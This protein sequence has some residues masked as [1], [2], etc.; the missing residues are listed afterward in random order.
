VGI[1]SDQAHN[2][3]LL[4]EDEARMLGRLRVEP[5]HLL[6]ALARSG[7]VHR[8]LGELGVSP[9]HIHAAIVAGGGLGDDLVLGRVPWSPA[10]VAVLERAVDAAAARGVH[11]PSSEHVMLGLRDDPGATAVLDRVGISD[12]EAFIDDKYPATRAPLSPDRLRGQIVRASFENSAPRPGPGP[13]VFERFTDEAERSVRAAV[14]CA[15]LLEHGTVQPLH[16]LL[17]CIHVADSVAGTALS[18]VFGESEM[19]AIGE[20]MER[21]RMYG[22]SPARQATGIFTDQ[23]RQILAEDALKLAY[24]Q[25]HPQITTGHLLLAT[26][27]VRDQA[28]ARLIGDGVMRGGPLTDRLGREVARAEPGREERRRA[29]DHD[30]IQMDSAIKTLAAEFSKIVPA[31]WTLR[32]SGRS[33]GIRLWAPDSTSERDFRIDLD[34]V[35]AVDGLAADRLQ[36]VLLASLEALQHSI[37]S[38]TTTAWPHN[39]NNGGSPPQPGAEL[40]ADRDNPRLRLFYGD[41]GAPALEL[42]PQRP[43]YTN[44]LLSTF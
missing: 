25:D 43:L 8:L 15:A 39:P 4:S 2:L 21:A 19:G 32:A 14:E 37:V 20:A 7:N 33:G 36:K 22:P 11:G 24:R 28:V 16:L 17:G 40:I 30:L 10:V 23:T 42:S 3:I 26:L 5:E 9:G 41:P 35:V 13:P 18:N 1:F 12:V 31:G 38:H 6:L 34:W 44:M 27:D 29:V